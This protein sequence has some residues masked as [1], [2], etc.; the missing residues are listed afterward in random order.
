MSTETAASIKKW[1]VIVVVAMI[2]ALVLA[3]L[4]PRSW[5]QLVG[6]LVDGSIIRGSWMGLLAGFIFTLAPLAAL[7]AAWRSRT[8]KGWPVFWVVLSV[9]LALPNLMTLWIALGTGS[10]AHAG[11]RILDV[12][13]PGFRGG[14]L[15]GALIAAGLYAFVMWRSISKQ[16]REGDL[17]K[18]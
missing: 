5:A 15:L 17:S 13:G 14:S 16:R 8:A 18:P 11:Q 6:N 3:A 10:S 9:V 2:V 1:A 12:N 4:I 7:A